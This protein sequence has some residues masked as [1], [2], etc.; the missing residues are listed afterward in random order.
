M[1]RR[2]APPPHGNRTAVVPT[3]NFSPFGHHPSYLVESARF[4]MP[5]GS[6]LTRADSLP[7]LMCST[8]VPSC[9]CGILTT[10]SASP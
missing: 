9:D 10:A 1:L 2:E 7:S 5:I 3:D 8:A 4:T 6:T